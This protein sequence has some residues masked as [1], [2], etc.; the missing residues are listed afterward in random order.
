[1]RVTPGVNETTR[2][3]IRVDDFFAPTVVDSNTTVVA[4]HPLN[5]KV[6][7]SDKTANSQFGW[8]VATTR[9]LAAV[10]APNDSAN[11]NSGSVYLYTRSLDGSNTWTQI[12]KL[13]P[14]DGRAG[15]KFGTTVAVT[16]DIV[17]VG[18]SGVDITN[19]IDF[20]AVYIYGRN[21]NGADQWGFVK[22]VLAPDRAVADFFGTSVSLSGDTIVV[23]ASGVDITNQIDFGAAYVFD[24]NQGGADQWGFMKKLLASDRAV[25]DQLGTSVSISGDTIVA[26]APLADVGGSDRGAAYIFARNQGGTNQWGQVKKLSAADAVNTDHFGASV[27]VNGDNAVIGSPLADAGGSDRGAAYVFARN[28]GG[29]EQ[30]GQVKKL[31]SSDAANSDHFG[32]AV[33]INNES[34]VVGAPGADGSG[35]I[36]YGA[37]YLFW[38]NQGGS[39]QWNQVD[40]FLPA[41]VGVSDNFGAAV[42]VFR[43]TVV[44]GAYNGL[45][46]GVR[47]GTAFMFRIKYDNAPQLLI[48]MGNL[49]LPVGV[50][51]VY[52]IPPGTFADPDARDVFTFSLAAVPA[53]PAWFGLDAGTGVFSGTPDAIGAYPVVLF[54]TDA[55]GAAVSNQFTV[56]VTSTNT[57]LPSRLSSS[58]AK[59]GADHVLTL[60]LAGLP[61]YS[62]RVL[63][64][65][66]LQGA[67]TV[68][69]PVASATMDASGTIWFNYTNPPTPVFFRAVCP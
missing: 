2:F 15:D 10:G 21:Q 20:G 32:S 11:T 55:D 59:F 5:A 12:K 28:Q 23:G 47:Y 61:G 17:V 66:N 8:A 60:S 46:S 69:T 24:R 42:A 53:A 41:A 6:T 30:W 38:Q 29:A 25:N 18:A 51:F 22:K 62:Y 44:V 16:D 67:A 54:A 7:A 64:A 48:P 13:L 63:Q 39:N 52:T 58:A 49:S 43:N 27:A 33:A 45:D 56:N 37:A 1:S 57:A 14:P 26:G 19:Q 35:G 36:D 9:D 34:V 65:T 3:T 40:K 31:T 68:W 50:P 4:V